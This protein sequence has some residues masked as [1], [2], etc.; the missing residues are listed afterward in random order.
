MGISHIG[1]V[2][3]NIC[4]RILDISLSRRRRLVS[5]EGDR[6]RKCSNLRRSLDDIRGDDCCSVVDCVVLGSSC[7]Q[8]VSITSNSCRG[9]SYCDRRDLLAIVVC[10]GRGGDSDLLRCR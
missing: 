7:S 1:A 3:R 8:S 9:D 2:C 4:D 5:G 10:L 6:C